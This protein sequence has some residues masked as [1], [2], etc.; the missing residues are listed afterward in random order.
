LAQ[1]SRTLDWQ[2]WTGNTANV[3]RNDDHYHWRRRC[4]D[5][6]GVVTPATY[7]LIM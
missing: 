7:R 6:A 2:Q 3:S 1:M 5:L 4:S